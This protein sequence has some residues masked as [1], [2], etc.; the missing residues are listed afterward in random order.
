[1]AVRP[2]SR[3]PS[4][5]VYA[6]LFFVFL[7]LVGLGLAIMFYSQLEEARVVARQSDSEKNVFVLSNESNS[8]A[9]NELK[10]AAG[11]NNRSVFTEQQLRV[12]QLKG[13]ITGSQDSSLYDVQRQLAEVGVSEGKTAIN[14]LDGLRQ[15]LKKA[16][17]TKEEHLEAVKSATAEVAKL[18]DE[19]AA[20]DEAGKAKVAELAKKI[21][22]YEADHQQYQSQVSKQI[23]DL[24]AKFKAEQDRGAAAI[25][26]KEA[27]L[28]KIGNDLNKAKLRISELI[29]QLEEAKPEAPDLAT[30]IDG[31]VVS[32]TPEANTVY[33]DLG[34]GDHMVLGMT[35]EVFDVE[36]GIEVGPDGEPRGKASIEVIDLGENSSTARIVRGSISRPIVAGDIIANAV[37]DKSRVYK[38]YVFGEFNLDGQGEPSYT[39]YDVVVSLIRKWGG[40]VANPAERERRMTALLGK[41]EAAGLLLPLD[42][43]FLVIGEEPEV[44]APIAPGAAAD[45]REVQKAI[46]AKK[47]WETYLQLRREAQE[48]SVPLINQHRFLALIGYYR[49]Q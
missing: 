4:G 19:Y 11:A 3:G 16:E 24:E 38:F 22:T 49:N 27:E 25:R 26:D 9:A 7:A 13:M 29:A 34:L 21:A 45:P 12:Q 17:E 40:E 36:R 10:S 35:F 47:K 44:P 41:G 32:V 30:Q 5:V 48:L 18:K 8:A 28:A 43:D 15:E 42:T 2:A 37:Y 31:R 39:D 1:M 33:I 6:L 20:L 46:A 23:E 14:V